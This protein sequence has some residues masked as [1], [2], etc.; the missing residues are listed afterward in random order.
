LAV[1]VALSSLLTVALGTALSVAVRA[2]PT[3]S[4]TTTA[5]AAARALA[6][7]AAD[8]ACMD[9]VT[10]C[11]AQKIEGTVHD[12][13]GDGRPETIVWQ[14]NGTPGTALTRGYGSD[15]PETV[16]A[17]VQEFTLGN[18]TRTTTQTVSTSAASG[19]ET[20]LFRSGGGAAQRSLISSS[21]SAGES[22]VPTLPTGA[23]GWSLTRAVV[24]IASSGSA[25][26]VFRISVQRLNGAGLPDGIS[27]AQ[28][29]VSE[30]T[31]SATITP[32]VFD[33]LAPISMS[34]SQGVAVLVTHIS[35]AVSGQVAVRTGA[36]SSG[37]ALLRSTDG[38]TTWT[39]EPESTLDMALYG[40]ITVSPGATTSRVYVEDLRARLR[41][42]ASSTSAAE[43]AVRL[44]NGPEYRP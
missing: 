35:G 7:L 27:L 11:T 15:N 8:V 29:D 32:V 3:A 16:L 40:T 43:I 26:G 36:R 1:A 38:G 30:N 12:R 37:A 34:A 19:G 17:G 25:D 39:A 21:A 13:D 18:S 44:L 42:G 31:L 28:F 33:M 22:I 14:W 41:T 20:T 4:A 2:V 10:V 24:G 5:H 9:S 23:S 6:R